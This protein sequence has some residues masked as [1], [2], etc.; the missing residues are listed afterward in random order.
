MFPA[1][2]I[3]Y[4]YKGK[5]NTILVNGQTGKVVCGVPWNKVLFFALLIV[6]GIVLTALTFLVMRP[7]LEA[8][9]SSSSGSHSHSSN[10]NGKLLG[11][12]IAGAVTMFSV[13][14]AKIRKV[15]KSIDLTQA[16]SIFNFVKK[17]QE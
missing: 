7:F 15:I 4:Y 12:I 3:T 2:F 1:W 11:V 5:H 10:G 9:F 17:R 16:N 14:I 13:G 6:T 8:M